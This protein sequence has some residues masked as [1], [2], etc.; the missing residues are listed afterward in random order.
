MQLYTIGHSTFDTE[1][2]LKRLQDN[3][4]GFVIDVRSTPFSKYANQYNKDRI[5]KFLKEN[6][7]NYFHM[8]EH[9]GAR[10]KDTKY[11]PHEYLDFELFRNSDIFQKGMKNIERGLEKY[12]IALMC[13]E[14][15]PIDCHRAIMVGRGFELDGVD[16][17]HIMPDGNLLTQKDF[18]DRL[19]ELY[20]PD[21]YQYSLFDTEEKKT[22]EEY[23]KDAYILKNK[24]IGYIMPRKTDHAMNEIDWSLDK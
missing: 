1:L 5:E 12:N 17:G 23:L 2:F 9:F 15:D 4:I 20:F 6:D 8:G 10:Q 19:L 14:K 3:D 18:N 21:R 16:V 13:T 24:E 11:Y 7:I 22:D